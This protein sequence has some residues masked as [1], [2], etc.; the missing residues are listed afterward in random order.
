NP[1]EQKLERAMR[2]RAPR[3]LRPEQDQVSLTHGRFND[4]DRLIQVLL[5][6]RPA[7]PQRRRRIEPGDRFHALQRGLRLQ[8]E[9]RAVIEEDH[10]PLVDAVRQRIRRIDAR[11]KDRPGQDRKSTRLNSSHEW[12]SYAVFCLKKKSTEV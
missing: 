12:I 2:L 5:A 8:P 10:H 6:P 1:V 4:L 3:N 7:A 11:F 9:R